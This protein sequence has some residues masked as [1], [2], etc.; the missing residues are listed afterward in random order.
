MNHRIK[1]LV[2]QSL[3]K[4]PTKVGNRIYHTLQKINAKSIE[5]EYASQR[6]TIQKFINEL[7]KHK[8]GISGKKIVEIGSGWLPALPYDLVF[9]YGAREVLTYDINQH[10]QT[11]TIRRFNALYKSMLPHLVLPKDKLPDAV[12][13]YPNVNVLDQKLEKGSVD[14]VVTRNVLEHIEPID[15]ELIHKQAFEY[16]KPDSFIIHQI[17]PSDHRAYT[18]KSLSLW[19]FLQY[20]K[21]E[22]NSIQTRFDY[23]NRLRMPEYIDLFQHCGF[24]V[25]FL[26]FKSA[27]NGQKLPEKIHT[28][29]QK[30]S[31]EELT[32]GSIIVILTRK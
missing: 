10:F 11:S 32:A 3:D 6:K 18:D 29:F 7:N 4:M 22:W 9:Q 31:K 25:N 1:T 30:F 19:D 15:L 16:L 12:K 24:N 27:H 5:E 17:S 13:Y 28:D 26:S 2:F 21:D 20:A 14:G 8:F 23:H